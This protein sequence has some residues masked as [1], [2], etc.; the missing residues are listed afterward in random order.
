MVTR[1]PSPEAHLAPGSAHDAAAAGLIAS[2]PA[3]PQAKTIA[4]N[5]LHEET[6][7]RGRQAD[8]HPDVA[9]PL[10]PEIEIHHGKELLLLLAQ[11]IKRGD[12]AESP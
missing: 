3:R 1:L 9:F 7:G 8:A 10:R 11:W 4:H 5:H 12:G 6:V 2:G